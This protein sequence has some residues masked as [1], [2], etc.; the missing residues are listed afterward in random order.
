MKEWKKCMSPVKGVQ[1]KSSVE[2]KEDNDTVNPCGNKP[3]K[4]IRQEGLNHEEYR[5]TIEH[6]EYRKKMKE[7]KACRK[8]LK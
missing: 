5:K 8:S 7:W 6:L 3:K 2:E 1:I 4:P